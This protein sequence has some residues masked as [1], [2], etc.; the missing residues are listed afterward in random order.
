MGANAQVVNTLD[1]YQAGAQFVQDGITYEV[2]EVSPATVKVVGAAET[3]VIVQEQFSI[4]D[5]YTVVD[6][7]AGLAQKDLEEVTAAPAEPLEIEEDFFTEVTYDG[8]L[9]VAD[10]SWMKYAFADVWTNFLYIKNESGRI[11]GD[12]EED[13]ELDVSDIVAIIELIKD[14]DYS[15]VSDVNGDEETDVSDIVALIEKIKRV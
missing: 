15:E 8:I 10:A 13:D 4:N 14:E 3:K 7:S 1:G 9:N 6:F 11:L 12:V 5:T 2:V